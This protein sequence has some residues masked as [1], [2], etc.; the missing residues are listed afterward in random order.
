MGSWGQV[1]LNGE[2]TDRLTDLK[3]HQLVGEAANTRTS[4]QRLNTR[5]K[6]RECPLR[7][8]GPSTQETPQVAGGLFG[9][10]NQCH[11]NSSP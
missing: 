6:N 1:H 10:L 11:G 7:T 3:I 5:L 2:R 8:E 4:R 9:K